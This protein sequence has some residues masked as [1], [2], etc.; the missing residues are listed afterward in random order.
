MLPPGIRRE[1][2]VK[3]RE[4]VLDALHRLRIRCL[5]RLL[6]AA[7]LAVE[8]FAAQQVTKPLEGRP[9]G[10]GPPVVVRELLDGLRRVVRQR[11][12]VRLAHPRLVGRI[13]EQFG[14]FLADG[15]VEQG[16]GL[17]QDAVEAA[18]A[19]DLPLPLAY[20]AQQVI[21][22]ALVAHAAAEEVPQRIRGGGPGQDV[23]AHLIHRTADVVRRRQRVRAVDITSIPIGGHRA[24]PLSQVSTGG[25]PPPDPLV[26]SD[27]R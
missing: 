10:R 2:L 22:P 20:P 19:A 3:V 6:H 1:H 21:K 7:E 16:P 23:V 5:Q 18:A 9:G 14:P 24:A 11:V 26:T 25:C 8:H 12:Q 13:G 27:R 4:H 15:G 17:F